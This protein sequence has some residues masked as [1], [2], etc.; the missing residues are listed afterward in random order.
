MSPQL[1]TILTDEIA[2][3]LR[4]AIPRVVRPIGSEDTEELLQDAITIAAQMLHRVGETGKQVTPGNIAYYV[5]LHMKSGR[6]SQSASRADVMACGTQLD[7]TSSMLSFEEEVGYDP[8]LDETIRLGELLGSGA[9]DPSMAAA[10]EIDWDLFLTTHDYRYTVIVVG[11]LEGKNLKETVCGTGV[12]YSRM[13]QLKQQ[14]ALDLREFLGADAI[15][16][17]TRAPKWAGTMLAEKERFA[18]RAERRAGGRSGQ[19]RTKAS[20]RGHASKGD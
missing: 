2:P 4:A 19:S 17:S 9:E 5:I 10:R 6:R 16:D 15:A 3:R 13:Y 7:D 18:C 12:G 8:E 1:G 20:G 14:L 11:I